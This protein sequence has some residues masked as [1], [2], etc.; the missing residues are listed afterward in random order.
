MSYEYEDE[1]IHL[2][3]FDREL[4]RHVTAN[5]GRVELSEHKLAKFA[6]RS[7]LGGSRRQHRAKLAM[8]AISRLEKKG[9]IRTGQVAE[10]IIFVETTRDCLELLESGLAT[11]II[12][13]PPSRHHI[14]AVT[15]FILIGILMFVVLFFLAS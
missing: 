15:L 12:A 13:P 5:G 1:D 9:F 8:R 4:L 10:D 7:S 2:H 14:V 11:R 3:A 6:K